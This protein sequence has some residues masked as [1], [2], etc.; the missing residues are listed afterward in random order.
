MVDRYSLRRLA[1]YR[2]GLKAERKN[3]K[4]QVRALL[5]GATGCA[6]ASLHF[7]DWVKG[8][9]ETAGCHGRLFE[10]WR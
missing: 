5:P 3:V 8:S 7:F 4:L 6:S 10:S 1:R 2:E 9:K